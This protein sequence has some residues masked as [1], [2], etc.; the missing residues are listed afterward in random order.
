MSTTR[1]NFA[2][3]AKEQHYQQRADRLPRK[4]V[5]V[6]TGPELLELLRQLFLGLHKLVIALQ[7]LI[8]HTYRLLFGPQRLPWI[9]IGVLAIAVFLV[10][11]KDLHFSW[12][13]GWPKFLVATRNNDAVSQLGVAQPL[14]WTGTEAQVTATASPGDAPVLAY[15]ERFRKVALVEEQKFGIPASIKMAQGLLESQAGSSAEASGNNNHFGPPLQG[16]IYDSAWENWR[17]HSLYLAQYR[18]KLADLGLDYRKWAKALEK[19]NYHPG[20]GQ[21]ARKLIHIIEQYGLD[22]LAK[23]SGN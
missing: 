7:Y 3:A 18:S 5:D 21:Y 2:T 9:K 12:N 14:G 20:E 19:M 4:E 6:P 13:L 10:F 22:Q 8:V 16:I 23:S 15:I 1:T 17:A 11:R